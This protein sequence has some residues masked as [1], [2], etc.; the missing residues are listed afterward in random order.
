MIFTGEAANTVAAEKDD[1]E[2]EKSG[3]GE[4]PEGL[5]SGEMKV[6]VHAILR[7]G[8]CRNWLGDVPGILRREMVRPERFELPT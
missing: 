3:E 2:D 6:E 1:E 5:D 4:R 7:A 8:Q